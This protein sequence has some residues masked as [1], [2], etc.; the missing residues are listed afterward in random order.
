MKLEISWH[1]VYP[2]GF[3]FPMQTATKQE[4]FLFLFIIITCTCCRYYRDR[5]VGKGEICRYYRDGDVGKGE[6]L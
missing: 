3:Y 6:I 5:D 1:F 4:L 2:Q